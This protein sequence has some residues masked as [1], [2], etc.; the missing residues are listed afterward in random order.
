M[1]MSNGLGF[2]FIFG[3]KRVEELQYEMKNELMEVNLCSP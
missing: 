2:L 1:N 3:G